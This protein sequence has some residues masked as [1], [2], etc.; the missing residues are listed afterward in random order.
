MN[1]FAIF[2]MIDIVFLIYAFSS[3]ALVP[4]DIL[5]FHNSIINGTLSFWVLFIYSVFFGY[6]GLTGLFLYSIHLPVDIYLKYSFNNTLCKIAN[7]VISL[8]GILIILFAGIH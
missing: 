5:F 2:K 4:I 6:F 3:S 7:I 8:L 1:K